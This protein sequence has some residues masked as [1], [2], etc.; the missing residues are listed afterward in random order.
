[1]KIKMSE[2]TKKYLVKLN[3][4]GFLSNFL[5]KW[6]ASINNASD[7]KI[8]KI[9][10]SAPARERAKLKKVFDDP[11]SFENEIERVINQYT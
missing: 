7:A 10:K 8:S 1:M 5:K 2:S 3:K 9:L 11:E 4:E 6:I